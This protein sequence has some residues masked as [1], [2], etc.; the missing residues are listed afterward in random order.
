LYPPI[1]LILLGI[2]IFL[3]ILNAIFSKKVKIQTDK[4]QELMEN[5]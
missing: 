3:T 1:F 5:I 4:E 2:A